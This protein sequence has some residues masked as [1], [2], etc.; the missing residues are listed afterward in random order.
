LIPFAV[1]APTT[2]VKRPGAHGP[3]QCRS[4][5]IKGTGRLW[6]TEAGKIAYLPAC[7]RH[8]RT[9]EQHEPLPRVYQPTAFFQK[10]VELAVIR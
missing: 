4:A 9:R 3:A 8:R 1:S 6:D 7:A 5:A 2:A 10:D